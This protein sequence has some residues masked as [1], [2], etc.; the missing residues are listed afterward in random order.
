MT[1][2]HRRINVP[3]MEGVRVD[4][5]PPESEYQSLSD[6]L[7]LMLE[8]AGSRNDPEQSALVIS[9]T[10]GTIRGFG[11]P[12]ARLTRVADLWKSLANPS[13]LKGN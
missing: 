1:A 7:L 2:C 12:N 10:L 4:I 13:A 5:E 8:E 3:E 9:A 6:C 11:Y